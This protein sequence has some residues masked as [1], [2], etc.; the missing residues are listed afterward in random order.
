[1][2]NL[3]A[4]LLF[5]FLA[6]MSAWRGTISGRRAIDNVAAGARMPRRDLVAMLDRFD[7]E[8]AKASAEIAAGRVTT[9][10]ED[11]ARMVAIAREVTD[12]GDWSPIGPGAAD[13]STGE[14]RVDG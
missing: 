4:R 14:G 1:M 3:Q 10:A 2:T 8:V 11:V 7:A 9:A 13:P 5:S 12:D 6:D